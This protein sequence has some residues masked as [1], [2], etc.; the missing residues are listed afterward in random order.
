MAVLIV[1]GEDVR[2]WV[3]FPEGELL[4]R[5]PRPVPIGDPA[6]HPAVGPDRTHLT[7][8]RRRRRDRVGLVVEVPEIA[9]CI[10]PPINRIAACRGV[11]KR[12]ITGP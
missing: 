12:N 7:R 4:G 2:V 1:D 6:H 5:Q 10:D 11:S 9:L 3:P 8:V